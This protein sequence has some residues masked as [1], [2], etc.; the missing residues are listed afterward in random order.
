MEYTYILLEVG[1]IVR[2][3]HKFIRIF[4]TFLQIKS[5]IQNK[6]ITLTKENTNFL[7]R[8]IFNF[9]IFHT[10]NILRIFIIKLT[11]LMCSITCV[12]RDYLDLQKGT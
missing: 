12:K 3:L 5:C 7:L 9:C 11:L 4:L 6:T 10:N 2:S 1:F 8:S